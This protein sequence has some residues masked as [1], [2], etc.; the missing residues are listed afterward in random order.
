MAATKPK[1]GDRSFP[2]LV[3]YIMLFMDLYTLARSEEDCTNLTCSNN[4]CS[5]W[6][7]VDHSTVNSAL[8]SVCILLSLAIRYSTPVHQVQYA[9]VG[10]IVTFT[11]IGPR[12][13]DHCVRVVGNLLCYVDGCKNPDTTWLGNTKEGELVLQCRVRVKERVSRV[14]FLGL[15]SSSEGVC[16]DPAFVQPIGKG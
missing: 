5:E 13:S 12:S 7:N 2:L 14:V 9:Y 3:F 16:S 10:Q 15:G 8:L 6:H 11:A 4:N 1:E